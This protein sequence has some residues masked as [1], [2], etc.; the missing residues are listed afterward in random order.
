[1]KKCILIVLCALFF[2]ACSKSGE[3]EYLY[4]KASEAY[5]KQEF[6]SARMFLNSALKE[7]SN[8]YQASFLLAKVNYFEENY[9]EAEKLLKK[10]TKKYPQYNEARLWYIR[11]LLA[12]EKFELCENALKEELSFNQTDWHVY[13]LY[14]LLADKTEQMDKRLSMCK[15]ALDVLTES[16]KVYM[17]MADLW[18]ILGVRNNAI[19]VLEK[20]EVISSSPEKIR[21]LKHKI[22]QGADIK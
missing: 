9:V 12:E 18:L 11:V 4:I 14:S 21:L 19:E 5:V 10:L 15:K 17:E 13:Y 16:E 2:I 20:A 22:L 3:A 8:F 7:D 6:D 1:M